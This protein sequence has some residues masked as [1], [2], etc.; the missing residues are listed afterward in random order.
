MRMIAIA[1]QNSF[2]GTIFRLLDFW[3]KQSYLYK[4]PTF[5]SDYITFLYN[6]S[7]F[8]QYIHSNDSF[9]SNFF[10]NGLFYFLTF[11]L[12]VF[13]TWIISIFTTLT[14]GTY[15][16][17]IANQFWLDAN[18]NIISYGSSF[19]LMSLGMNSLLQFW[20]GSGFTRSQ[21]LVLFPLIFLLYILSQLKG[22][23]ED[24]WSNSVLIKWIQN[25]YQ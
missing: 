6:N 14:K 17:K 1:Y 3:F 24:F 8:K 16:E 25:I 22:K 9:F 7:Y 23:A 13:M 18:E 11:Q 2:F 12:F 5:I 20:F 4:I 10:K 15:S 21:M 19:L